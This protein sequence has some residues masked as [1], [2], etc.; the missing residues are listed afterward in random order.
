MR[1]LLRCL[2]PLALALPA[3]AGAQETKE[4]TP[5]LLTKELADVD[6]RL[7]ALEQHT[8]PTGRRIIELEDQLRGLRIKAEALEM[9]VKNLEDTVQALRKELAALA[10]RT[11]AIEARPTPG[12][13]P[14]PATKGTLVPSAAGS[15][16]SQKVSTEAE[17]VTITGVVANTGEKPLVFVIVQAEFLDKEGNVVKTESTYTEPRVVPAGSTA[18]FVLKAARDPRAQDHRL[19]LRTE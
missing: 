19:S 15:I 11:D 1:P 9:H 5:Q 14:A 8:R 4:W 16:R 3:P 17:M 12:P 10:G 18:T 7:K 2:L 13:A 6:R